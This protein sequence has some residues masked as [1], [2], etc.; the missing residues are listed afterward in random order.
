MGAT[1]TSSI[2][3]VSRR[4]RRK[5]STARSSEPVRRRGAAATGIISSAARRRCDSVSI[6]R[7]AISG[8]SRKVSRKLSRSIIS[9][10]TD[11]TARAVALRSVRLTT[12]ISPKI[13]PGPNS[14]RRT[15]PPVVVEPGRPL[16]SSTWPDTM[17]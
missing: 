8:L 10:I 15:R 11:P 1:R 7:I 9:T 12:P 2:R 14:A 13:S 5:F 6:M 17:R 3:T 16:S 4:R